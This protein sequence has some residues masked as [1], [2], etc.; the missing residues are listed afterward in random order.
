[1]SDPIQAAANVIKYRLWN[2]IVLW[3]SRA[4]IVGCYHCA[5]FDAWGDHCSCGAC[6][7][8]YPGSHGYSWCENYRE[9]CSRCWRSYE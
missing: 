6:D 7:V 4:R 2:P 8:T 3:L 5:G 1:M 9:R